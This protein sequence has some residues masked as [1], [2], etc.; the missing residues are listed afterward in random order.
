M[1]SLAYFASTSKNRS[2][3]P[4]QSAHKESSKGS[5]MVKVL[6]AKLR[7]SRNVTIDVARK[8]APKKSTRRNLEAADSSFGACADFDIDS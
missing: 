2:P 4:V 3:L 5:R 7:I 6:L 8:E 1:G